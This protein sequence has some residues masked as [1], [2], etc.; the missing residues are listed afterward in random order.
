M[1]TG[2]LLNALAAS[3][4]CVPDD[5]AVGL[6]D[7]T[8]CLRASAM[9]TAASGTDSTGTGAVATECRLT[10]GQAV[11]WIDSLLTALDQANNQL[12][13]IRRAESIYSSQ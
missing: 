3:R 4:E 7:Y 2:Q 5:V 10:Y 8:Y 9:H 1:F 13:G 12:S 6:L 11:Y